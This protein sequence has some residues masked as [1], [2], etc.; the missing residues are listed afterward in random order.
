L[1]S[2]DQINNHNQDIV[3]TG[4]IIHIINEV[5][6]VPLTAVLEITAAG[7]E[8][9]IS[10]LNNGGYLNM[11][12][13]Y[14]NNV[15]LLPD[16]TFFIPNSAIALAN[17][18]KLSQTSTQAEQQAVFEYHVVPSMVAYSPQLQN[19]LSLKTAQGTNLTITVQDGDT[20]VNAAKIIAFD[21]IVANGV[22]HVIDE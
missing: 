3:C 15:L 8:Y 19:G 18:T 14:V 11:A 5:L 21:Y 1:C 9:F 2:L 16:V 6:S 17:A 4:G 13:T 22:V 12:N 7:L 10:I 20:Y